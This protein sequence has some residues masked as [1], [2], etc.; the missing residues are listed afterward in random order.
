MLEISEVRDFQRACGEDAAACVNADMRLCLCPQYRLVLQMFTFTCHVIANVA[1]VFTMNI[2]IGEDTIGTGDT[3]RDSYAVF[4]VTSVVTSLG[5]M[6]LLG[7][8]LLFMRQ[9]RM[10]CY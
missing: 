4:V 7:L 2:G 9:K 5:S 8:L 10:L 6:T 1:N 3:F